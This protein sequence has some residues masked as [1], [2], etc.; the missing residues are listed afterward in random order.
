MNLITKHPTSDENDAFKVEPMEVSNSVED[1]TLVKK[2]PST[3]TAH[4]QR[5]QYC[6]I[7]FNNPKWSQIVKNKSSNTPS[8]HAASTVKQEPTQP[9]F[10]W[11]TQMFGK[12]ETFDS[13]LDEQFVA[14][15]RQLIDEYMKHTTRPF[16]LKYFLDLTDQ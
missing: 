5:Q 11:P 9:T 12:N 7:I 8:E 16:P 6:F 10:E 14:K 1:K 3:Y 4:L 2:M 13:S 15:L